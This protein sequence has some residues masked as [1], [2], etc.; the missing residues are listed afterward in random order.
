MS[1]SAKCVIISPMKRAIVTIAKGF[2]NLIYPL[3]CANCRT[4]L[5][6]SNETGL[7]GLCMAD[8]RRNPKPHCISCGRPVDEAFKAC[9]ECRKTKFHFKSAH[10][11]YVYDGALKELIHAFKY[12]GML[13]L[14]ATLSGL[15]TDFIKENGA[16]LEDIDVITFVPLDGRRLRERGF[17][18]S[19]VIA[20][21]IAQDAGIGL[22]GTI[23]EKSHTTRHQ[24]ELSR[25][26][27]LTN[28]KGAFKVRRDAK[29]KDLRIL[30][31]DD[32]MTT[33]STLSECSKTLLDGGARSVRCLTLARGI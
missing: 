31:I 23:L 11:A 24:N 1:L 14:S 19:K 25:D 22:V 26:E 20:A 17:N 3:H 7:C 8:I 33:G 30:L 29:V 5:D 2:I 28:L 13:S 18:Q 16:I 12:K 27:R 32:V 10:S 21:R 4:Y 6:T 15:M 9:P